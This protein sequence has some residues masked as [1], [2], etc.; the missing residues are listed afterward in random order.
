M[1][2]KRDKKLA[3]IMLDQIAMCSKKIIIPILTACLTVSGCV[4]IVNAQKPFYKARMV[5]RVSATITKSGLNRISLMPEIIEQIISDETQCK[6]I[7]DEAGISV[8]ITPLVDVG[9]TINLSIRTTVGNV[10]DIKL[11]VQEGKTGKTILL[12]S[13]EY[14][15]KAAYDSARAC[16]ENL[17]N[18]IIYGI[19]IDK[20]YVKQ[21]DYNINNIYGLNI[22]HKRSYFYNK[23]QGV[24]LEIKACGRNSIEISEEMFMKLFKNVHA[25]VLG[26]NI[27][28]L[29]PGEVI[30]VL[31]V[32]KDAMMNV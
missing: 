4:L 8:Y 27:S 32:T 6:I 10:Q 26:K 23:Y 5:S 17:L 22:L 14:R 13:E 7:L 28:L 29:Q 11:L 20:Y 2:S 1:K 30:K 18:D 25:V 16:I 15:R 24:E 31:I 12:N 19:N 21:Y 3:K 9:Q